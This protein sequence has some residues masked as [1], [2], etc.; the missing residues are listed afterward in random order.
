MGL[1]GIA[2]SG[3][4]EPGL[5]LTT[6]HGPALLTGG[7]FGLEASIIPVFVGVTLAIQMFIGA[8]LRTQHV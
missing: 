4:R 3:H 8:R 7:T 5:F 1:L 6:A 2:I